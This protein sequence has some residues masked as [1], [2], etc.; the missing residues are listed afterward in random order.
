MYHGQG[1]HTAPFREACLAHPDIC[2]PQPVSMSTQRPVPLAKPVLGPCGEVMSWE[3]RGSI[4]QPQAASEKHQRWLAMW[5]SL[6]SLSL[7]SCPIS[8]KEYIYIFTKHSS[9]EPP[10]YLNSVIKMSI[11]PL[12]WKRR[13]ATCT[14]V[15]VWGQGLSALGSDQAG[16]AFWLLHSLVTWAPARPS[17]FPDSWNGDVFLIGALQVVSRNICLPPKPAL[18]LA[19]GKEV[20]FGV[21]MAGDQRPAQTPVSAPWVPCPVFF[22]N[23]RAFPKTF[24]FPGFKRSIHISISLLNGDRPREIAG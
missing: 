3:T 12:Q 18:Q 4:S 7:M 1:D 20:G 17:E 24:F 10:N 14:R 9:S 16:S 21:A 8:W 11:N 23:N 13:E 19:H 2:Q 15:R 5:S 22:T 6:P